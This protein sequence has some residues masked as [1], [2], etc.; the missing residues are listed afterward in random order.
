MHCVYLLVGPTTGSR[1]YVSFSIGVLFVIKKRVYVGT[2]I[3]IC[4]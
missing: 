1:P 3:S 4:T 2:T